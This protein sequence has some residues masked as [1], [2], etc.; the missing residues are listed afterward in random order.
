MEN[1]LMQTIIRRAGGLLASGLAIA[2]LG[3]CTAYG[4]IGGAPDPERSYDI[5]P[6]QMPPPGECR[7]WF[8]DRPPGQQPP[9]GNC[10]ELQ[11]Q[12]PPGAVLVRG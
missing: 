4:G 6:G 5:P 11:R 2:M 12:V 8:P 3:G 1:R 10:F 9:P 7:I